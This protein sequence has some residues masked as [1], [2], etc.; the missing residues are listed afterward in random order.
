MGK[1]SEQLLKILEARR[2]QIDAAERET[3]AAL[4]ALLDGAEGAQAQPAFSGAGAA[5]DDGVTA[6]GSRSA[7]RDRR[8]PALAA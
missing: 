2:K 3:A 7:G 1:Y 4:A 6:G 5:A 8:Q